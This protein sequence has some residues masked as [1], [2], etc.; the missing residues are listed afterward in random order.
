MWVS[1][2][3]GPKL[4]LG[5]ENEAVPHFFCTNL[6]NIHRQIK[7]GYPL[8]QEGF[9]KI[10]TAVVEC[11]TL[12]YLP[13]CDGLVHY[14]SARALKLH[15]YQLVHHFLEDSKL[16][17]CRAL[18]VCGHTLLHVLPNLINLHIDIFS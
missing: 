6:P 18:K 11:N 8:L 17:I 3:D 16:A 4:I 1:D 9:T 10:Y 15:V 5:G 12:D 7:R 2:V 14:S 13:L